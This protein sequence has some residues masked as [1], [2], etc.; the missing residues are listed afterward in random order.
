M[1]YIYRKILSALER[2]IPPPRSLEKV[3]NQFK[4]K[5]QLLEFYLIRIVKSSLALTIS[6]Y[7]NQLIRIILKENNELLLVVMTY[8]I[9]YFRN[10]PQLHAL[11]SK[12]KE[13]V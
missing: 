11:H 10:I 2:G 8:S 1:E 3:E 13:S 12:S 7:K 6:T 9:F 5:I 4:T